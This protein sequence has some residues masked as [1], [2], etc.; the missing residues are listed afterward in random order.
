MKPAQL[1]IWVWGELLNNHSPNNS[2]SSCLRPRSMFGRQS[3]CYSELKRYWPSKVVSAVVSIY[4]NSSRDPLICSFFKEE[5]RL[6]TP[7]SMETREGPTPNSDFDWPKENTQTIVAYLAIRSYRVWGK[8]TMSKSLKRSILED[9]AISLAYLAKRK[10]D[11]YFPYCV[12]NFLFQN[13]MR[14]YLSNFTSFSLLTFS[15]TVEKYSRLR[16]ISPPVS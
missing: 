5:I 11:Q 1:L 8:D 9:F 7:I 16:F 3:I 6:A 4:G 10:K 15:R 2:L 12:N 14:F 13:K